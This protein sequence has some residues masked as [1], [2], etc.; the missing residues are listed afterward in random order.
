MPL[1]L[2]TSTVRRNGKTYR[3]HQ[4]VRAIRRDGKPT[5]EVVAHLGRLPDDEARALKDG[6]RTL[7]VETVGDLPELMVRFSEVGARS[8]LRFLDLMVVRKAWDD[9]DLDGFFEEHLPRR[10]AG[11][12]AAD[13]LF[14]LVANR[15]LAPCSKLR[16]VEWVPRTAL[17]E[18]LGFRLRQLN[19]SRIHRV[20]DDL[21]GVEGSLTRWLVSH[22]LR[23][24]RPD[25]VLFLDLTSSWFEGHGGTLGVRGRTKDGAIRR[26]VIQIALAVDA[27][28]F[29]VRWEVLP[30]NA[31]ESKVVPYWIQ[32]LAEH[33]DLAELPLV[34]DRGLAAEG[35]LAL[36][37]EEGRRFVTCA[38]LTRVQDYTDDVKLDAL[39]A[40]PA[41][42]APTREQLVGAG[43]QPTDDD[44]LYVVDLGVR[45]PP[46]M[47]SIPDP[48]L[49][50]VPYFRPSLY[51][52]NRESLERLL[53]N[54]DRQIVA[55]NEE[56]R[57]AKASRA[58]DTTRKKVTGMLSRF[59]LLQDYDV[60]LES[61]ELQGKTKT[62]QSFQVHLEKRAA[63]S[64]RELN[65]G[66]MLLLAHPDDDRTP[67]ELVRQYHQ[68]AIVEYDFGVIK[69][70]LDLRPIYHQA[71]AKIRAH[72][73]LCVLGL[74]VSRHLELQLRDAGITDAIDRVYEA[75]EP[76]RLAVL[77]A[78]GKTN[79]LRVTDL[80]DRQHE[81]LAALGAS[82]LAAPATT[83]TLQRRRY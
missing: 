82:H 53:A 11:M 46:Q 76:C 6:L 22:P 5:H 38:R 17:P 65:C 71:D 34:F 69:S 56:L 40:I 1:R 81:L 27:D 37:I 32:A 61:I 77:S 26:H 72:V 14:T 20:L 44:D 41:G 64:D 33:D 62:I 83:R 16:V 36:L 23:R 73:T 57:R 80:D 59:G 67:R 78:P 13:V 47:D 50:L 55:L 29:P 43:L 12:P 52:R 10:T 79:G 60:R 54:V 2:R 63:H 74:L 15:C 9:W 68:K 18:L 21:E 49:R 42:E 28:G 25:T 7:S 30:G 24:R 19:N 3:Y 58:E 70:V 8:S 75:L 45:H 48:G 4:L 51:L 39:A 35:N 66:W 31:S